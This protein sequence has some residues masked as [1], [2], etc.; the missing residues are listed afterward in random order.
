[1]THM[2]TVNCVRYRSRRNVLLLIRA[3]FR[4]MNLQ[5]QEI[6]DIVVTFL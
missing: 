3:T 1:M 5:V 6:F 4:Q 2:R